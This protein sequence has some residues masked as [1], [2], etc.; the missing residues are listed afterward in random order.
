[1]ELYGFPV[2]MT[3]FDLLK[4]NFRGELMACQ[5]L[6]FVG[7]RYKMLGKLVTV[8]NIRTCKGDPMALA[9]FVD[10]TGEAFDTVLFPQ[11]FKNYPFQGDGVYLLLGKVTEEFGQPSLEVEKMARLGYKTLQ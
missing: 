10:A 2:S 11:V 4:T 6:N 3:W 1:M 9:T 5:M 7:Q 8:K